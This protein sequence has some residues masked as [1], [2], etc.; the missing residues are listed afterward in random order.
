MAPWALLIATLL[1]KLDAYKNL[2]SFGVTDS[3]IYGFFVY[4]LKVLFNITFVLKE[5]PED[6]SQVKFLRYKG[7]FSYELFLSHFNYLG[8]LDR[9]I[10]EGSFPFYLYI[11][12]CYKGDFSKVDSYVS[13]LGGSE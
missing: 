6:F 11:L 12:L 4:C 2:V 1:P 3:Q 10:K 13:R 5:D 7:V 9:F 8:K